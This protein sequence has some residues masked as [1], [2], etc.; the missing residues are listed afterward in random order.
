[1]LEDQKEAEEKLKLLNLELEKRIRERTE[2]LEFAN[3][4]LEA[5]AYS[6]SHDLRAPLRA[7]DGFSDAVLS[8]YAEKFDEKGRHYLQRIREGAAR[9]GQLIDDLLNLSR[10]SRRELR[11]SPVNLSELAKQILLDLKE[12][13][14]HTN[15]IWDVEPGIMVKA[16]PNLIKIALEN[17]LANA[18]KFSSTRNPALI[19][20][21]VS[22]ENGQKVYFVRD[23]GIGFDMAYADKLFKPF[24][25]LHSDS[26]IPG[27]GIGLVTV[28]RII[29]R[30]GG[31]IW[32]NA[33]VNQGAAF[34]FTL[35]E[36]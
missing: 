32:A 27:T 20:I 15:L 35:G 33:Q 22:E 16:D 29:T 5:F 18:I 10:I 26:E 34:F 19:Q 25:R 8:D 21:G 23:N 28:Q 7:L 1:V 6:V 24:Q 11:I 30:H 36:Q 13:W 14:N 9:M 3:K 4:E 12:Q 2:Q 17:L 31:R